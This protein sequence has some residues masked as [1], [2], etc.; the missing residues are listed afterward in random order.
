[1]WPWS[2]ASAAPTV[3]PNVLFLWVDDLGYGD[4]GALGNATLRTPHIDAL[5]KAGRELKRH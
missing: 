4:V 2:P 1:M 3:R 5:A